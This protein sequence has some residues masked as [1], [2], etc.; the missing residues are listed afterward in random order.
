[1]PDTPDRHGYRNFAALMGDFVLFSAGLAFYD[2]FVVVPAFVK[3]FA[4]SELLVGTLSALRVLMITL[5]Q[6][7]AASVLVARPR[8]KPLLVWSS[9]GGRLPV[10]FLALATL[11][12][13][14][15]SPWL[16]V[17]VLSAAVVLFFVSEGLN[18]ISWP[19]I[20]GKAIPA[21]VRGRFFGFG[22]LFSSLG[23]LGAGLVVRTVL[24]QE[25]S[26]ASARWATLFVCAF[27]GFILSVLCMLFIYEEAEEKVPL[28]I[29]V[30]RSLQAMIGYLRADGRLRRVVILQLILGTAA[31]T[32]PFFVIRAREVV[33]GGD[34]MIG[35]FLVMQNL[36]G[37]AA[38]LICGQLID[39]VGSWSAIRAGTAVQVVSLLTVTLVGWGLVPPILYLAAFFLLGFVSGSS[40]WSFSAY[41]LDMA[42]DERRPIYLATSG[43][44][45]SP[46]FVSSILVGGLFE[47]T[48]PEA[49]FLTALLLSVTAAGLAWSLRKAGA[50]VSVP[51]A[52]ARA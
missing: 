39:R 25:G 26:P 2:P 49:V 28:R 5:P 12:W 1:M 23:A 18:S 22:Q 15:R 44:L 43:I 41:L 13:A 30:V 50:Q 4:G 37:V 14:D 8:K 36:G 46:T 21:A 51:E 11:L 7:W 29:D 47:V 31:A 32:F 40:W 20:V 9:I 45:T 42:T 38:A 52:A 35:L 24:G 10:L 33:P 16:V 48:A 6:I 3:T 27:A 34:Q 17:G 19:A